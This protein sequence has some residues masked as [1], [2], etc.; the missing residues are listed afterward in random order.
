MESLLPELFFLSFFAPLILRVGVGLLFLWEAHSL[1]KESARNK[2]L[3]AWALLI[4]VLIGVGF[5][6]QLA[7]IIGIIYTGIAIFSKNIQSKLFKKETALL[8]V[9]MLVSLIITGAGAL[10]IDFPY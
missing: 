9:F 5:L 8:V 7:A 10:A 1:P 3:S 4:A 6:T 2:G